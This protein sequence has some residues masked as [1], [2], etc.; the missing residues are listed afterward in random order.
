M[1]FPVHSLS[2]AWKDFPKWLSGGSRDMYTPDWFCVQLQNEDS[3]A[4]GSD[5]GD[6]LSFLIT[7][8]ALFPL[9]QKQW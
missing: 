3:G 7:D 2:V 8:W 6:T 9:L 4:K 5:Q 1:S